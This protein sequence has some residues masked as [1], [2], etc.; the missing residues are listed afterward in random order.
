MSDLLGIYQYIIDN[1]LTG[2]FNATSPNP[3]NNYTFTKALG[4]VLRRPT[5]LPIPEFVLR[6][7][8]GEAAS[9]ITGSKQVYPRKIMES[10]YAFK[11]EHVEKALEDILQF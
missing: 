5:I 6:V 10:G 7:M 11:F 4:K 2:I 3:V 1:K 9:V 8:Y